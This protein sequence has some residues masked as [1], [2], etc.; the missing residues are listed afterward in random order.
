MVGL[1]IPYINIWFHK[2]CFRSIK[3]SINDFM[4]QNIELV[5]NIVEGKNN[6]KKFRN[7]NR[8]SR[9]IRK[10]ARIK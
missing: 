7:T 4:S 10:N 2:E 9:N 5:Y 6:D 8:K 1:D 3:E